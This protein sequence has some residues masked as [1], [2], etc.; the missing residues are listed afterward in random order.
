MLT[1]SE[2]RCFSRKE[3]F[4]FQFACFLLQLIEAAGGFLYPSI[5]IVSRSAAQGLLLDI[6]V[7]FDLSSSAGHEL[8]LKSSTY[9]SMCKLDGSHWEFSVRF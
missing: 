3:G 9:I 6:L 8:N 1:T 7:V 5:A 4:F 2:N